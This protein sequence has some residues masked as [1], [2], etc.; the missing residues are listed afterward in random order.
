[1]TANSK[2][3]S[4]SLEDLKHIFDLAVDSPTLCSGSFETED[5]ELL[6]RI[7]IRIGVAPNEVTPE[8][9]LAQYPHKFEQARRWTHVAGAQPDLDN[10]SCAV[11]RCGRHAEDSIHT[12]YAIGTNES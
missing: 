12:G 11:R 8:E 9:F 1:M 2:R 4:I 10:P 7:A 6:R 3:V 5:V